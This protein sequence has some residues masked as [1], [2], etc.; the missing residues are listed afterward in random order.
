MM[1]GLAADYRPCRSTLS[2]EARVSAKL[3]HVR[4]ILASA[5]PRRREL[6]SALDVPFT[7]RPAN[8]EED[9]DPAQAPEAAVRSIAERKATAA[10]AANGGQSLVLAADTVVVLDGRVLGKP[11]DAPEARGMLAALA[12]RRHDV[13]TAVVVCDGERRISETVCTGVTMRQ[14]STAEIDASIAAGTPFD[15]A[16]GYAIQDPL[17]RPVE[18][19]DGCYCNV[20]GLPLWTV[21]D[22]LLRLRPDSRT[23][24]PDAVL[25]RCAGCPSRPE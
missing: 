15:K 8:A 7:V 6:L 13:Y 5:S 19:F 14:Y 18:Q 11:A 12:G 25:E 20:M 3:Q 9:V 16:G 17:L 10:R 1:L 21:R 4:L 23:Q 22:L 2:R 24:A